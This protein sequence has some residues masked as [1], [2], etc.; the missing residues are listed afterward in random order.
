MRGIE[1]RF[2]IR[3]G[4]GRRSRLP[5]QNQHIYISE[6]LSETITG[7]P[8][9]LTGCDFL[10][11]LLG[12]CCGFGA[13]LVDNRAQAPYEVLAHIEFFAVG[14]EAG[15]L[16]IDKLLAKELVRGHSGQNAQFFGGELQGNF[17]HGVNCSIAC[18]SLPARAPPPQRAIPPAETGIE[19]FIKG[20]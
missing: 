4:I 20:H 5:I 18:L 1:G 17:F 8:L 16:G 9:L 7:L 3:T 11:S 6:N 14:P 19:R 12:V 15:H 10:F 13:L 2:R